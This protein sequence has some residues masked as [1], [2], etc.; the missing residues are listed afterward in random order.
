MKYFILIILILLPILSI[1]SGEQYADFEIKKQ[2]SKELIENYDKKPCN[3][4]FEKFL[5]AL[6]K[7]AY[8]KLLL[9]WVEN[10]SDINSIEVE[11]DPAVLIIGE[12]IKKN[13]D[14]KTH[15]LF[16]DNAYKLFFICVENFQMYLAAVKEKKLPP[17]LEEIT[18]DYID[19][20]LLNYKYFIIQRNLYDKERLLKKNIREIMTDP[21]LKDKLGFYIYF[22]NLIEKIRNATI[23]KLMS[24]YSLKLQKFTAE[25]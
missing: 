25:K 9:R 14:K 23:E 4:P 12:I 3:S 13:S 21:R 20:C 10:N 11:I 15:A 7:P 16:Y 19:E 8:K 2:I 22:Y 6:G 1:F 17:R 24:D 18:S 5:L